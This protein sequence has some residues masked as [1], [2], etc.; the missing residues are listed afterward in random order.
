MG[1]GGDLPYRWGNPKLCGAGGEAEHF[2]DHR[3]IRPDGP[4]ERA[5][6]SSSPT[7]CTERPRTARRG[8]RSPFRCEARLPP[9]ARRSIRTEAPRVDL[10]RSEDVLLAL[11]LGSAAAAERQHLDL[12]RCPRPRVRGHRR[13]GDRVG[14][15]QSARRRSPGT[16]ASRPGSAHGALPREIAKDHPGPAGGRARDRSRPKRRGDAHEHPVRPPWRSPRAESKRERAAA[17]GRPDRRERPGNAPATGR[18]GR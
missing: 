13:R 7:A 18:L 14:V 8:A 1:H 17:R 3:T 4:R 2:L 12:R 11:H 9:R 5:P 6:A 10:R 15:P 16:D